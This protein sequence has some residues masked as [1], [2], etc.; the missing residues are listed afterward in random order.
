MELQDLP[1]AGQLRRAVPAGAPSLDGTLVLRISLAPP[2]DL[3]VGKEPSGEHVQP[4]KVTLQAPD[5]RVPAPVPGYDALVERVK[6]RRT[7]AYRSLAMLRSTWAAENHQIASLGRHGARQARGDPASAGR[8]RSLPAWP[9]SSL[10]ALR[11]T[12][13]SKPPDTWG[14]G[15]AKSTA[16]HG[17]PPAP[18][19]QTSRRHS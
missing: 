16:W 19:T 17:T 10:S 4:A 5:Q 1:H 18:A 3:I 12:R 2:E 13:I 14:R 8:R 7:T 15:M 11:R 9:A 6:G